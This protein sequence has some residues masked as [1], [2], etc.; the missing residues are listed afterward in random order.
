MGAALSITLF[1]SGAG[2]TAVTI[3]KILGNLLMAAGI[4]LLIL[5]I[6]KRGQSKAALERERVET[7]ERGQAIDNKSGNY[8]LSITHGLALMAGLALSF[9]NQY[10]SAF[11]LFAVVAVSGVVKLVLRAHYRGKM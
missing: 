2:G 10:A 5:S 11:A 6:Y 1:A 9:A 4:I 7:D 8:A 3:F